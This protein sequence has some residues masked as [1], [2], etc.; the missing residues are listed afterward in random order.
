MEK[1]LLKNLKVID[2]SVNR[3]LKIEDFNMFDIGTSTKT[4]EIIDNKCCNYLLLNQ[5]CSIFLKRKFT[6]IT[7]KYLSSGSS[8][9]I[10]Y[11]E[12]NED[13]VYKISYLYDGKEL[14]GPNLCESIFLN[15]F[16]INYP[17]EKGE[18]YFPVQNIST[19]IM[20]IDE[21]Y[22][23]FIV[24]KQIIEKLNSVGIN[25]KTD[26]IIL[27]KMLNYDKNLNQKI[28]LEKLNLLE[29]WESIVSQFLKGIGL[30]HQENL[31]HG[32]LKSTNI[33]YDGNCCKITDFGGVKYFKTNF[34]DKSCTIIT[35]PP[36]DIFYEYSPP[37]MFYK[38]IYIPSGEKGD[39]WSIG[40]ILLEILSTINPINILYF[41][42]RSIAEKEDYYKEKLIEEE[43]GRNL[44][45][46][47]SI[48]ISENVNLKNYEKY[49]NIINSIDS[50]QKTLFI[51]PNDRNITVNELYKEIFQK[52]INLPIKTK[53]KEII[54]V[55][56]N[57]K[58][59]LNNFRRIMYPKL[60][61]FLNEH[62]NLYSVELII[63][64]IDR[65]LCFK[66]N[67]DDL[68]TIDMC[69]DM[70][71]YV[72]QNIL[73][74]SGAILIG[75][76]VTYKQYINLKDFIE[77]INNFNFTKNKFTTKNIQDI[78][79]NIINILNILKYDIIN[80]EFNYNLTVEELN[81]RVKILI[82]NEY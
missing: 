10:L 49:P 19:E 53:N 39:I 58:L 73:L 43:I 26:Y 42:L 82:Q 38:K 36:E 80:V 20:M 8:G 6:K 60:F 48:N 13:Y 72:D 74:I 15:Y 63:N 21:F 23:Y 25:Y 50:I 14:S 56:S 22:N 41:K 55:N 57:Y 81:E 33:L 68:M 67:N 64:I 34:Y 28:N 7:L 46:K 69:S 61:E 54:L 18:N 77:S 45:N 27:N 62:N 79:I 3:L 47:K 2:S 17:E 35:R 5:N 37:S 4:Y 66:L 44:K 70:L 65:F 16:N 31:I 1:S 51:N 9:V 24:D 71:K 30:L 29:D 32:D 59:I 75:I 78:I 52:D 12:N 76:S 11:D 40:I